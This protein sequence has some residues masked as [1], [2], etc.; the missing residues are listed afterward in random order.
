MVTEIAPISCFCL[1]TIQ[2][3]I[4]RKVE[5][6]HTNLKTWARSQTNENHFD[7]FPDVCY[8]T[9]IKYQWFRGVERDRLAWIPGLPVVKWKPHQ[10][11]Q[12]RKRDLSVACFFYPFS[13][14]LCC[15]NVLFLPITQLIWH[16]SQTSKT[17]E[18]L[19]FTVEKFPHNV[20]RLSSV[21]LKFSNS[22][23]L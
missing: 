22:V 1:G 13:Y 3:N 5:K 9:P 17:H 16:T 14:F 11:W 7:L 19:F 8:T 6:L 23:L 12:K 20:L 21:T 10:S 15:T 4:P 18:L 2:I